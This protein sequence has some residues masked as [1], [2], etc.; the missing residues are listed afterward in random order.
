MEPSTL[1]RVAV[2]LYETMEHLDPGEADYVEW[3]DLPDRDREFYA[4]TVRRL[5]ALRKVD[6]LELLSDDH[7]VGRRIPAS[8]KPNHDA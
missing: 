3:Q 2:C 4:L 7:D 1:E 5:L 8:E 6:L